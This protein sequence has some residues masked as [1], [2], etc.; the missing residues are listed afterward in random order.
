MHRSTHSF[1]RRSLLRTALVGAAG[2]AAIGG[3]AAA[4]APTAARAAEGIRGQ[5]VSSHQGNVD[6]AA[7]KAAGSQFSY[8][9]ATQGAWYVNP[10]FAQQ[11]NGSYDQGLAHG[12]YH[13]AE[14][15]ASDPIVECDHFLNNGGGW[16]PDGRTMPGMLDVEWNDRQISPADFQAW[17]Q[18]W[19]DHYREQ[20]GRT[21]VLYTGKWFWDPQ[22]GA[23]WAPANVPLHVSHY[24]AQPPTSEQLPGS[25]TGYEIWQYQAEGTFAGDQNLWFG[26]QEQFED[27]LV[28]PDYDPVSN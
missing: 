8:C 10:Y 14:A 27:F 13:F 15:G 23:Q 22:V 3:T 6:W 21:P 2:A 28:N 18:S 1:D 17:V 12:A 9:K 11:Y 4:L 26:T 5:D 7:Q 25:W 24:Q 20:T 19:V 16:S